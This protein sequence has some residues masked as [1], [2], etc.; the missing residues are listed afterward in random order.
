MVGKHP[1]IV[2][3]RMEIYIMSV[4]LIL[5]IVAHNH[6]VRKGH[7]DAAMRNV[8]GYVKTIADDCL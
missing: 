1:V 7:G 3:L 8:M 5:S 6:L 2:I 4:S